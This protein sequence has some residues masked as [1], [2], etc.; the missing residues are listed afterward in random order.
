MVIHIRAPAGYNSIWIYY[1]K[2]EN[3]EKRLKAFSGSRQRIDQAGSGF[4]T[5]YPYQENHQD[6][7]PVARV[8]SGRQNKRGFSKSHDAFRLIGAKTCLA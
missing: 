4:Q 6:Q 7:A 3:Q 1:A 5:P 8:S 2:D